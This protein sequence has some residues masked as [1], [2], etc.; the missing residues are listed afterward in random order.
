MRST[1]PSGYLGRRLSLQLQDIVSR[2]SGTRSSFRRAPVA[3]H[4]AKLGQSQYSLSPPF[5]FGR[6]YLLFP[7]PLALAA[8]QLFLYLLWRY[9]R[10]DAEGLVGGF[11]LSVGVSQL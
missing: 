10:P 5:S 2:F 1:R 11:V 6:S 3:S 7:L 8:S 4:P 9:P